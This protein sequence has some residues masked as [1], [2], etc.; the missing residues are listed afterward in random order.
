M[1]LATLVYSETAGCGGE[2]QS[3][4]L[5][6]V[7]TSEVACDNQILPFT[8]WRLESQD[9]GVAAQYT[10]GCHSRGPFL[11]F[12]FWAS[13]AIPGLVASLRSLPLSSQ[14]SLFPGLLKAPWSLV[15]FTGYSFG[16]LNYN[17]KTCYL[18]VLFTDS[19][20]W[21]HKHDNSTL[22]TSITSTVSRNSQTVYRWSY[23]L[24]PMPST[25][26][27]SVRQFGGLGSPQLDVFSCG[28]ARWC[29]SVKRSQQR[30]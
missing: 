18:R 23:H 12:S 9:Q 4:D 5:L 17:A 3:Q 14:V 19:R 16:T 2:L 24:T 15:R 21:G 10:S 1:E 30:E 29:R 28:P 20:G 11:L 6:P 25:S 8:I 22:Y 26:P 7:T 13:P 27:L